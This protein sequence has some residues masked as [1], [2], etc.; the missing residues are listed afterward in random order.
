MMTTASGR[1]GPATT[2]A[3]TAPT[4]SSP[5]PALTTSRR[6]HTSLLKRT[7]RGWCRHSVTLTARRSS[8][9]TL[10][11]RLAFLA[12]VAIVVGLIAGAF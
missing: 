1:I 4:P 8:V 2:T 3:R 6:V 11:A 10:V 7:W 9:D 5:S 12:A